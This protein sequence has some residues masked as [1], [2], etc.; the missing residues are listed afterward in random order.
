MVHCTNKC[1]IT[2]G[3][4]VCTSFSSAVFT[5][6]S[7]AQR[8]RAYKPCIE[9]MG[10]FFFL[11][12]SLRSPQRDDDILRNKNIKKCDKKQPQGRIVDFLKKQAQQPPSDTSSGL[13][14]PDAS[15]LSSD[16]KK[17]ASHIKK[18]PPFGSS[19][20]TSTS[21]RPSGDLEKP[22]GGAKGH[23]LS[24]QASVCQ[25]LGLSTN[26]V[27][28]GLSLCV[29]RKAATLPQQ[30]TSPRSPST[31]KHH[32]DSLGHSADLLCTQL[33]QAIPAQTSITLTSPPA[34]VPTHPCETPTVDPIHT[35]QD[36]EKQNMSPTKVAKGAH[37]YLVSLLV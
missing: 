30:Q 26:A 15:F 22:V 21:G 29:Y 27:D 37:T 13:R 4:E 20:A 33:P 11:T 10:T 1:G 24:P 2:G 14:P 7:F 28:S 34:P 32:L 5:T 12:S 9:L 25:P 6:Y 36:F 3:S 35:P 18:S 19:T 31:L 17:L 8:R 16:A 23:S